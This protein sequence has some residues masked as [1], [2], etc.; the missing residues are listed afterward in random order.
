VL[1][2]QF[3]SFFKCEKTCQLA[4]LFMYRKEG[5]GVPIGNLMS[6]VFG[7]LY[8]NELDHHIK[9]V[10]KVRYY[11]RYVDDFVMMCSTQ[12]QAQSLLQKIT[13]YLNSKLKLGV[14]K[15]SITPMHKGVNCF[16]YRTW[17]SK[18]FIRKRSLFLAARRLKKGN[19]R[20]FISCLGHAKRTCSKN[21]L[22]NLARSCNAYLSIPQ[23]L[24]P[25]HN[26]HA[27]P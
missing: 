25:V 14:S 10:L 24:R 18:R 8:L 15:Y 12:E 1:A 6:Q 20:A 16:G 3:R 21:H 27:A 13:E 4:E 7:L 11:A 9:R 22:I 2:K 23:S 19:I 26:P 17:A 5:V